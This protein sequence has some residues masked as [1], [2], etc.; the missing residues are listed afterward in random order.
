MKARYKYLMFLS[1]G[2]GDQ[3]KREVVAVFS[4]LRKA[5]AALKD[6]AYREAMKTE[7][8]FGLKVISDTKVEISLSVDGRTVTRTYEIVTY[9]E[10]SLSQVKGEG[11]APVQP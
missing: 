4:S 2:E 11:T 10:D 1:E 3:A 9:E 5:K 6:T 8:T 7:K